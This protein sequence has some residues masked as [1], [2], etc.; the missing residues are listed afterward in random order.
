MD[1]HTERSSVAACVASV[2]GVPPA[3][4]PL[5]ETERRAWLAERGVGLVPVADPQVFA[6]AG[7]WIAWRPS[8]TGAG[9]RAVVMFGVPSGVLWDPAG[10]R[11]E[12]LAGVVLSPL[13]VATWDPRRIPEP[14]AGVVEQILIG[15]RAQEP[16][17]AVDESTAIAGRGLEGDRYADGAG[18]FGSGRPGSA[19]TLVDASVL[20]ALATA[21][22][23]PVDH[24]RNVVV[25]GTDLNALV[26]R[27]FRL[28]SAI[29]QGRRLCEPCAHLDRL[30][31]GGLLR[32][33][34]HRGGLR[35]DVVVGGPVRTGDAL[36][37]A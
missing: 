2:L 4:V 11:E 32:P 12:I 23:G 37:L 1:S 34:V 24:R 8:I 9:T 13:D 26:G 22:G 35:A 27:R 3:H 28:G 29:C 15:S 16:L 36:T 5:D 10:T 19:L 14:R 30:S 7:P 17:T 21:R 20:N 25:R 33:L 18:T 31:G 6:W